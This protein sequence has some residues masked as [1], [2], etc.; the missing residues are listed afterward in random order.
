MRL[1][2][3][4]AA[5]AAAGR[6]LRRFVSRKLAI[7]LVE[8]LAPVFSVALFRRLTLDIDELQHFL[9]HAKSPPSP[10]FQGRRWSYRT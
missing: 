7:D 9:S 3:R 4:H 1:T 8:I 5:L 2:E 6:L 10:Y